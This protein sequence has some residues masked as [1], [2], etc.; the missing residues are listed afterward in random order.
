MILKKNKIIFLL[1]S[2]VGSTSF[3]QMIDSSGI[4]YNLCKYRKH[5]FIS[6]V[7]QCQGINDFYNYDIIQLCRN[8][9]DR[10][11]SSYFFQRQLIVD[12]EKYKKF[13][14]LDFNNF[15]KLIAENVKHLPDHTKKF[16]LNVFDDMNFST[17]RAPTSYGVR[18][19]L[20]QVKW[21]DMGM[22]IKYLKLEDLKKDIKYVYDILGTDFKFKF[23]KSNIT[24]DKTSKPYIEMYNKES[25]E[26][27]K[28]IYKED[29]KKL[30]YAIPA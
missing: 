25:L 4:E 30:N 18:F 29:F 21:N 7:L 13:F 24:K 22:K 12:K 8:P 27:V 5:P 16:C 26:L 20:P 15:V 2:K 14:D 10:L 1:P 28:E 11:V 23:P 6:E 19:Y 17:R 3:T 9:I